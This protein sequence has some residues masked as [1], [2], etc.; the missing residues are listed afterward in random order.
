MYNIVNYIIEQYYIQNLWCTHF[1]SGAPNPPPPKYIYYFVL[2]V[3]VT[4]PLI[5]LRNSYKGLMMHFIFGALI[6][7]YIHFY[8]LKTVIC[9][10]EELQLFQVL[11]YLQL[12]VIY[13]MFIIYNIKKLIQ[14][15]MVIVGK[16]AQISS[17][18]TSSRSSI[19]SSSINQISYLPW[20][21]GM[22]WTLNILLSIY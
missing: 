9:H 5:E 21:L 19:S 10:K 8:I 2:L 3:K 6:G 12:K 1:V 22:R 20:D 16:T 18:L 14:I 17:I 15:Q 13:N 4:P 7:Y 11:F